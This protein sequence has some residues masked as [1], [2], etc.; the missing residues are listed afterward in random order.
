MNDLSKA[1]Q[2]Y[3]LMQRLI[4]LFGH[5]VGYSKKNDS[6]EKANG[7][8]FSISMNFSAKIMKGKNKGG[9]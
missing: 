3:Q 2:K 6:N 1:V 7:M 5:V 4:F 8:M 9:F